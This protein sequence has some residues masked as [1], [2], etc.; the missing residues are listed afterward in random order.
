MMSS[1]KEIGKLGENLACKYLEQNGYKIIER[2][3]TFSRFCEI[4]IIAK[5]KDITVFVEVKTRKTND[6]GTPLEAITK[7]KYNH[8]KQGVLTYTSEHKLSN[9]R[10]DA[11]GITLEPHPQIQHLQNISIRI[12]FVICRI[13]KR[14]ISFR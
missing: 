12:S 1:N 4:D 6:F 9:F 8:I 7:T 11:I 2:N 5:I 13:L 3:K 10:I 14:R